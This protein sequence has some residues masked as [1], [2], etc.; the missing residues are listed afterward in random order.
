MAGIGLLLVLLV[1]GFFIGMRLAEGAEGG[2]GQGL[3][4]TEPTTTAVADAGAE[5][6]LSEDAVWERMKAKLSG[7]Q[8]EPVHGAI[9]ADVLRVANAQGKWGEAALYD[10]LAPLVDQGIA[11]WLTG[12]VKSISDSLNLALTATEIAYYRDRFYHSDWL[13]FM[14]YF[15]IAFLK[16]SGVSVSVP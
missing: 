3:A 16:E 15:E 9:K 10:A 5:E 12:E 6:A 14:I 7:L 8:I 4:K 2:E 11:D 13:P 1:A